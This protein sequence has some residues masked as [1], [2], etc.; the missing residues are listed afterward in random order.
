MDGNLDIMR[1]E[2]TLDLKPSLVVLDPSDEW[3]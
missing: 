1:I 3:A 2:A